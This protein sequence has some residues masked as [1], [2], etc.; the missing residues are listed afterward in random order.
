MH[1]VCYFISIHVNRSRELLLG[2]GKTKIQHL[3]A[4]V[5]KCT[6]V[7]LTGLLLLFRPCWLIW[8][9]VWSV[10]YYVAH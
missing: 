4:R 7:V 2:D 3:K 5:S 10:S 9:R 6:D 1:F 8:K